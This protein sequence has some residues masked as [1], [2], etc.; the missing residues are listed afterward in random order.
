MYSRALF[1]F[2]NNGNIVGEPCLRFKY[3]EFI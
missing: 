3:S 1:Y 2:T